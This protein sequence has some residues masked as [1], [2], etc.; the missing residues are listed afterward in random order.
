MIR[1]DNGTEFKNV[2]LNELCERKGI[3]RQISSPKT[4][5][6]NGV[7]ERKNRTSIEGARSMLSDSSLPITFWAESVNTMCYVHNRIHLVKNLNKTSYELFIGRK[8]FI[9]FLKA[10]GC[11]CSILNTRDYVGKFDSKVDDGYFVGYSSVSKAYKVFNRRTRT[12]EESI[13]VI[14]S[15]NTPNLKS[16]WCFLAF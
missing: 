1:C 3:T 8:P 5:Q 12:I 13:N 11:T 9:G 2:V 10:F 7:A 15:E 4:P 6:Q 16:S 14:F